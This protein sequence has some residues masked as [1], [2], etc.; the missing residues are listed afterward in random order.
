M[1]EIAV[2]G[3]T[4]GYEKQ[5]HILQD[6]SFRIREGESVAIVG[7]NGAG[8]STLLKL[9]VGLLP[10]FEGSVTFD[11]MRLASEN[12]PAIREKMGFVFQDSDNQLFMST[13]YEDIAFAPRN[14][15]YPPEEVE[16][17]VEQAMEMTRTTHLRDKQIYK[18]S[19]GEKKLVS[20]ATVLSM[21]P[22]VL[23][24]DEPTIALDPRNRRN[25]IHILNEMEQSKIIASHDLDF[26][27]DCCDRTLLME[28]GRILCDGPTEEI[29][30][31]R[32]LLEAHGLE[33]P[34]SLMERTPKERKR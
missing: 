3:L 25:L 8:K 9:L 15:G 5:E 33:L 2:Q 17:R 34:L 32:E 13:V 20:I 11:D 24:M 12:L 19:G 7:A 23:L 14:Y 30:R 18:M 22:E 27:M 1:A 10:D 26:V 31:D 16:R 21:M 28:D 6:I 29:L 4:F